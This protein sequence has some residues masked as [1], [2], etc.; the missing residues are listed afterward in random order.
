MAVDFD[1]VPG[2][3]VNRF[4]NLGSIEGKIIDQL[5]KSEAPQAI[6]L[7]RL[8]KYANL[9]ALV[10]TTD[11]PDLTTA[12]KWGLVCMEDGLPTTKR[13]FSV[14]FI[15]DAWTQEVSCLY[16]YVDWII[17]INPYISDII[18]T[19][20]TV[21]SSKLG[22]LVPNNNPL[23]NPS[24]N[25]NDY[26]SNGTKN[27]VVAPL[28]SRA[29]VMLADVCALFNGLY[30]DDIGPM[31]LDKKR[32]EKSYSEQSLWNNRNFFGHSTHFVLPVGS[33]GEKP[34]YC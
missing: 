24:A 21:T 19:V 25:P 6:E 17:P 32:D 30:I 12:E 13:V 14:P 1:Y 16:I 33:L 15:D 29:T 10:K 23:L 5:V 2:N 26:H 8:L 7:W 11:T 34:S 20:E 28:K 9:N 22:Y 3:P 31:M 27:V 18:I 4:S